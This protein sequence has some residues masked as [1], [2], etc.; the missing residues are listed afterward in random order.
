[1][2]EAGARQRKSVMAGKPMTAG[3]NAQE[4]G[5]NNDGQIDHEFQWNVHSYIN[6]YIRYADTKAALVIAYASAM[7]GLLYTKGL[8]KAFAEHVIKSWHTQ[9]CLSA[10]AFGFLSISIIL[11]AYCVVPRLRTHGNK[12]FIFW[13]DICRHGTSDNYGNAVSTLCSSDYSNQLSMHIFFLAGVAES[14]FRIV[15]WSCWTVLFGSVVGVYLIL[16]RL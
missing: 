1:M 7:I 16:F 9:A 13:T 12:G 14:K 10:A 15:N 2:S 4:D 5:W 11:A 8:H 3:G 6:E